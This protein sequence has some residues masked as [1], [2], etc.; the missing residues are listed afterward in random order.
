[1]NKKEEKLIK[2]ITLFERRVGEKEGIEH[3]I[4][5]KKTRYLVIFLS[6]CIARCLN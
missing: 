6:F 3:K 5:K 1:M 2:N 4:L